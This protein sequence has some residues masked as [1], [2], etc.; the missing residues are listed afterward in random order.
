MTFR[1]RIL[2]LWLVGWL[3]TSLVALTP[4]TVRTASGAPEQEYRLKAAFL[5]NFIRFISWPQETFAQ[6]SDPFTL[7]I[8]G[9]NPFGD[10]LQQMTAKRFNNR[11]LQVIHDPPEKRLPQCEMVFLSPSA[12]DIVDNSLNSL[13]GSRA[14][15][16]SDIPGFVERGGSI[17]FVVRSGRL[18]FIINQSDLEQRDIHVHAS[19]LDLAAGLR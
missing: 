18:A 9:E 12:Q 3:L 6:P 17:E 16:V 4:D 2:R 8:L 1:H 5:V 10:E 7:C 14:V 19:M 15:T 13:H 11:T